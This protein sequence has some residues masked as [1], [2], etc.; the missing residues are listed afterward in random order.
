LQSFKKSMIS[1]AESGSGGDDRRKLVS[2]LDE[3]PCSSERI[4]MNDLRTSSA[5]FV[6]VDRQVTAHSRYCAPDRYRDLH[7]A[8]N[9]SEPLIGRGAGLSYVAAS[10]DRESTSISMTHFNRIL[11]FDPARMEVE[12]EAGMAVGKLSAFLAEHMLYLPV[13]PGYP[14]ITVGGCIAGN[15]H[16]KNQYR[17]GLFSDWIISLRLLHPAHGELECSRAENFDV[18]DLTCGGLGL[19]GIVLA[20]T[21]RLK[22]LPSRG[23]LTSTEWFSG[24]RAA[25]DVVEKIV[26]ALDGVLP[27]RRARAKCGAARR[28]RDRGQCRHREERPCAPGPAPAVP[29]SYASRVPAEC[30]PRPP[31]ACSL[32]CKETG[33]GVGG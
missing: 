18:F 14:Q 10:F 19:T 22:K 7:K 20:A 6:S 13:Q 24:L 21:L 16:G 9:L 2:P 25:F 28:E 1:D 8:V 30:H 4:A 32:P 17:D 11:R 12:V 31:C 33:G 15:V 5:F 29:A 23:F 27:A 26:E 3:P